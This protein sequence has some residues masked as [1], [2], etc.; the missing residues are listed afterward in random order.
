M[1]ARRQKLASRYRGA[2]HRRWGPCGGLVPGTHVGDIMTQQVRS[3]LMSRI[4]GKNTEPERVIFAALRRLGLYFAKHDRRLPGRPDIVLRR[5]RIAIFIDG[6]FWH[7][8]R[9]PL[10]KHKLSER[11]RL[12]ITATRARDRRNFR[13][14]RRLGWKVIR[15]WEHEIE[16][17]PAKCVERIL[18][19][20][21][22]RLA[23]LD[24]SEAS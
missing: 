1:S 13:K 21:N 3:A 19:E 11:W 20:R 17:A 14:L 16:K 6:S 23:A 12:K 18:V 4:K 5:A 2:G 10:W 7:G 8:W 9:F 22:E 15:I 24:A